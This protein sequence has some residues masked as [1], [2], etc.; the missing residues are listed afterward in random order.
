MALVV[1]DG[2]SVAG[3]NSYI[4]LVEVR[5]YALSRGLILSAVDATVEVMCIKAM[6]YL[7]SF[8]DKFQGTK[9]FETQVLQFPRYNVYID[10]ILNSETVIPQLLKNAQCQLVMDISNGVDIQPTSTGY[11]VKMERIEGAVTTE[12]DN[13]IGGNVPKMR[14]FE[15]L[16]NPLLVKSGFSLRVVRV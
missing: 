16:I 12:Y 11:G 6:D 3:A 2:T 7:E 13:S 15:N 9:V 4:T 14:V 8:R 1:E 10:S 5:A